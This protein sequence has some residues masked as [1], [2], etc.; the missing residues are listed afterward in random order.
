VCLEVLPGEALADGAADLVDP[1]LD[2]VGGVGRV[3]AEDDVP[4]V[5][6]AARAEHGGHAAQCLLFEEVGELVEGRLGGDDVGG[7]VG[8]VVVVE[9]AC[10]VPVRGGGRLGQGLGPGVGPGVGEHL[11][12]DVDAVGLGAAVGRAGDEGAGAAGH[13]DQARAGGDAE[14]V[15]E[16]VVGGRVG[17]LVAV[18]GGHGG[19]AAEIDA[20]GGVLAEGPGRGVGGGHVLWCRGTTGGGTTR[21]RAGPGSG[22]GAGRGP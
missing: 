13:V 16:G 4:Q 22:P 2:V 1:P 9:E 5:E 10:V 6:G 8:G 12:G 14:T 21:F 17:A 19:G 3:E 15:E 18:V 7:A 20:D 11:G